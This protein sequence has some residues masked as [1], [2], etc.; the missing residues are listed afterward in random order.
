VTAIQ[1]LSEDLNPSSCKLIDRPETLWVF[2]G[3]RHHIEDERL[4]N[5]ASLRDFF[6][7][8]VDKQFP[9][10]KW[11]KG[12]TYPENF[13][14][15]YAFSGYTDL[16]E[17][18]RDACFIARG[19]IVFLESEG[20]LAEIG[21]LAIDESL[22]ERVFLIL[23]EQ[24]H[25]NIS[26]L[27][28]GPITRIKNLRGQICVI[29]TQPKEKMAE[30]EYNSIIEHINDWD[31][32]LDKGEAINHQNPGHV[33]LLIADL[34]NILL[35]SKDGDLLKIMPT[36]GVNIDQVQLK[37]YTSLLHYF[38]LITIKERGTEVFYTFN[39][40]NQKDLINYQAK[41]GK[42]G[43]DRIRIKAM[44]MEEIKENA[45]QNSILEQVHGRIQ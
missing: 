13:Q 20:S 26:Y 33:I 5:P 41:K 18:E 44:R 10:Y 16:H 12:V 30:V 11:A 24:Y 22:A 8:K 21:A 29:G 38:G 42:P 15:W 25:R 32:S 37:K 23:H 34:I 40:K 4:A 27:W 1:V 28:L 6:L 9:P 39:R 31:D 2:G 3:P 35:V 43:F 14:D 45:R 17:F 7:A 36:F 19:V